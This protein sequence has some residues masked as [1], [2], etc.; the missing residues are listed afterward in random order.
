MEY[1]HPWAG[2]RMSLAG[3]GSPGVRTAGPEG[4]PY[5]MYSPDGKLLWQRAEPLDLRR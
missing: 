1:G 5:E 3:C 4:L 2:R